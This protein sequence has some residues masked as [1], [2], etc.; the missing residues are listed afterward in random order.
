[1][2]TYVHTDMQIRVQNYVYNIC[3]CIYI[4]TR[5]ILARVSTCAQKLVICLKGAGVALEAQLRGLNVACVE[6]AWAEN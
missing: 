6:Q 2:H 1:M 4:Y 3:M 5:S